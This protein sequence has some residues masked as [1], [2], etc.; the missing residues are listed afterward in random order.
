[1]AYLYGDCKHTILF[2]ILTLLNVFQNDL[3]FVFI[4]KSC[5]I[6]IQI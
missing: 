3:C 4:T 6:T 5:R 2:L 1:M